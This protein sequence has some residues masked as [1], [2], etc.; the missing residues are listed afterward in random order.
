M[1]PGNHFKLNRN[2]QI[3]QSFAVF[4]YIFSQLN[5]N[6]ED[7][8]SSLIQVSYGVLLL[9]LVALICFINV[10][11]FMVTY[12]LIHKGDYENRYPKLQKF[13]NYYKNTTLVYVSIEAF[14]CLICLILLVCFS[15]LLVYYGIKT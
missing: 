9:S 4:G 1:L 8:A 15:F 14:L 13:I 11:C 5:L 10:L 12:I 3:T 7:T 6:V 2:I